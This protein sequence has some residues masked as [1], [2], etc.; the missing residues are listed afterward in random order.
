MNLGLESDLAELPRLA[1]AVEAFS[2]ERGL[3]AHDRFELGLVLEEIFTNIVKYAFADGAA[4]PVGI[5]LDLVGD[6]VVA[7]ITDHGRAFDP[8][9]APAP[10]LDADL[11]HRPIGG[12]GIHFVRT[13]TQD[14][15]YERRAGINHLSFRKRV[16]AKNGE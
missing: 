3:S 9:D 15:A 4:H 6:A 8:R 1:E 13:L 5:R 7:E 14:L 11:E 12:L 10:D 2:G 16:S